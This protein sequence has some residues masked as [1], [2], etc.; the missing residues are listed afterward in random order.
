VLGRR[1]AAGYL[2][3]VAKELDA[4]G[5]DGSAARA[6]ASSMQQSSEMFQSLRYQADLRKGGEQLAQIAGA[7]L[8]ALADMRKAW[9]QVKRLSKGA[10][11]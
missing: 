9:E 8:A 7:E 5:L 6:A 10:S 4:R 11:T 3:R 2:Q 1:G